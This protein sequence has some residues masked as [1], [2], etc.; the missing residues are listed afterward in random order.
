MDPLFVTQ[1]LAPV[2]AQS[3]LFDFRNEAVVELERAIVI[4][5]EAGLEA[6]RRLALIQERLL[7]LGFKVFRHVQLLLGLALEEDELLDDAVMLVGKHP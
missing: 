5:G 1:N 4:N 3:K 7:E 6:W 2:A